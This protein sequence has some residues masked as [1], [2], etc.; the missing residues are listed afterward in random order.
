MIPQYRLSLLAE[1]DIEGIG[2]YVA[3]DNPS[4]ADRL[5]VR[6]F[7]VF[8]LLAE[9]P[10]IGRKREEFPAVRSFAVKPYLI[11]YRS[12]QGGVEI[13]RVLHGARDF[14]ELFLGNGE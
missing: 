8:A 1:K 4:A 2:C 6:F 12:W 11:F 13:A 14:S 10:E 3:L 5:I 9:R 7:E